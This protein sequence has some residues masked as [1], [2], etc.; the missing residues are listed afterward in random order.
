MA[1]I[2]WNE[3]IKDYTLEK[4]IDGVKSVKKVPLKFKLDDKTAKFRKEILKE[5]ILGKKNG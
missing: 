3:K 5:E 2:L 4:E 1:E